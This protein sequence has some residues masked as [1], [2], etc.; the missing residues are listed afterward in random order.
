ML[1]FK[2][3]NAD[4]FEHKTLKNHDGTPQRFIRNGKNKTWKTRPTEFKIPVKRGLKEYGY[5]DQDNYLD[6]KIV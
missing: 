5:I 1:R 6:F 4:K 2:I 3:M